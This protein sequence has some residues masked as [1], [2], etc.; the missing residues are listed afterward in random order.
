MDILFPLKSIFTYFFKKHTPR[1]TQKSRGREFRSK[2][3]TCFLGSNQVPDEWNGQP[4]F[5]GSLNTG[6]LEDNEVWTEANLE[7]LQANL[8]SAF[9]ADSLSSWF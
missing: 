1:P 4:R 7:V 6:V 3:L 9:R 2:I 8:L 5:L